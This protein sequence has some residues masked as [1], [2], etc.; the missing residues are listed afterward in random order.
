MRAGKVLSVTRRDILS[1]DRRSD[2]PDL[3]RGRAMMLVRLDYRDWRPICRP[4][5][6]LLWAPS[7]PRG[8]SHR[9][10]HSVNNRLTMPPLYRSREAAQG[11]F[12]AERP[13]S[14]KKTPTIPPSSQRS[15]HKHHRRLFTQTLPIQAKAVPMTSRRRR[16]PWM[17][18][19]PTARRQRQGCRE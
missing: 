6:V 5:S 7:L 19:C 14:R 10:I 9:K 13:I 12:S 18:H 16:P 1:L 11:M 8:P 4:C 3:R 2:R 15:N 17:R